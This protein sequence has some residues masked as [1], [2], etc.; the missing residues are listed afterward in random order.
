MAADAASYGGPVAFAGL[1]V[2]TLFVLRKRKA[3]TR[4]AVI[5]SD[6]DEVSLKVRKL[7]AGGASR[8]QVIADFDRTLTQCVHA[9]PREVCCETLRC[10]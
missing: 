3:A 6:V 8:L 10:R 5:V 9:R 4:P 1:I 2:A 7:A